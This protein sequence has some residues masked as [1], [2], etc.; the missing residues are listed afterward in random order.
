MGKKEIRQDKLVKFILKRGYI[1]KDKRKLAKKF[2]VSIPTILKDIDEIRDALIKTAL[3]KIE[4]NLILRLGNR[5]LKMKDLDLIRL[6]YFFVPKKQDVKVAEETK[7]LVK[8]W[9]WSKEKEKN[10]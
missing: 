3:D 1:P 6:L 4:E 10:V 5:I 8:M 2:Q 9:H 7:I